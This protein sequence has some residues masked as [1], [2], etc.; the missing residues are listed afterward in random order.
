MSCFYS[1]FGLVYLDYY[2][3]TSANSRFG[4]TTVVVGQ[5]LALCL[6]Q[7]ESL[8]RDACFD[9]VNCGRRSSSHCTAME[10]SVRCGGRHG[11]EL[12]SNL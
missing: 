3:A 7:L 11:H 4:T 6:L 8:R 2:L 5:T 12:A 10:G 9:A 1:Q